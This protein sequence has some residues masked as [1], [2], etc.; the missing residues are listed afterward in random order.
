M[1]AQANIDAILKRIRDPK[2]RT[3]L[4]SLGIEITELSGELVRGTMPVDERTVQPYGLLH[5][6]ASVTLAETLASLGAGVHVDHEKETVVGLEIN[7]NHI[8]GVPPGKKI[9]GEGRPIHLGRRTQVWQMDL[10]TEDGK[11]V[12]SS[13]C[14]MAIVA[15]DS[16]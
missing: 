9:L 15:L 6:G 14:T 4:H 12:C 13:R 2:V 16:K 10:K 3:V 8:R 1:S 7:A 5:G 11:L